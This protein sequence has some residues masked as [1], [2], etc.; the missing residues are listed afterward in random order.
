MPVPLY[1][2]RRAEL[3]LS[4]LSTGEADLTDLHFKDRSLP[5]VSCM[6]VVEHLGL[7]RYGDPLNPDAD[8]RA[9]AEL[10]RVV[11]PG[12]TL[13]FV[14]PVGRPRIEFNAHRVYGFQHVREQFAEL[15]L[16]QFAMVP[17]AAADGGLVIDP[18]IEQ[19][20][21]EEYACG[22]FWFQRGES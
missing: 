4:G 1:E 18:P 15:R 2:Y 13:L 6:H 14:V 12:G 8:L 21:D 19:V 11:A 3:E 16:R 22:C 10:Q 17:T 7:G 9:M 20:A 5:S